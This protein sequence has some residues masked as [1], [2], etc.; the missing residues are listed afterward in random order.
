M[1]TLI[2]IHS[3]NDAEIDSHLGDVSAAEFRRQISEFIVD[4]LSMRDSLAH[5][6]AMIHA[7]GLLMLGYQ[8]SG[9]WEEVVSE[10]Y[11]FADTMLAAGKEKP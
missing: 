5:K 11:R 7:E 4:R 2:D 8:P 1:K 6:G 9:R 10:G 3:A